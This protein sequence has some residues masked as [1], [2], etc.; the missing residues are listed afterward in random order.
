MRF[1]SSEAASKYDDC[2][3]PKPLHRA[4]SAGGI[5]SVRPG[6]MGKL[7]N[8]LE[9]GSGH[10]SADR[11]R[12][13][14]AQEH[15]TTNP[16]SSAA[17]PIAAPPAP[18]AL[19][20][21]PTPPA[22][23]Y[24]PAGDPSLVHPAPGSSSSVPPVSCRAESDLSDAA[25]SM[26]SSCEDSDEESSDCEPGASPKLAV[27]VT[28]RLLRRIFRKPCSWIWTI[29]LWLYLP[30]MIFTMIEEY[31][32]E[33]KWFDLGFAGAILLVLLFFYT[34][35]WRKSGTRQFVK[36]KMREETVHQYVQR[37]REAS[38]VILFHVE[39]YH[40]E[41]RTRVVTRTDSQGYRYQETQYYQEKVV[42][43][44][45]AEQ[46]H[47]SRSVDTTGPL[48]G[49][50]HCVV[51]KLYLKK[52]FAFIDDAAEGRYKQAYGRFKEAN[53]TDRHQSYSTSFAIP[54]FEKRTLC[55][56]NDVASPWWLKSWVFALFSVMTLSLPYRL[57][58]DISIGKTS[59]RITKAIE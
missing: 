18:P 56:V 10:P 7:N 44:V 42:S 33:R 14:L 11:G 43:R 36:R 51:T 27:G 40:Y 59:L 57:K 48:T 47:I 20:A 34:R 24:L 21:L 30:G 8:P 3:L 53:R 35:E 4:S 15:A 6:K 38:P 12:S 9:H 16:I 22:H 49:L 54:E 50:E 2:A 17:P 23:V 52:G 31:I 29:L 32:P 1:G 28:K 37:L 25:R 45:H 26:A 19:H 5:H 58:A 13:G 39:C 55:L 41:T 46:F